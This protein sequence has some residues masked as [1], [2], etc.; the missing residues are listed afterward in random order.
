VAALAQLLGES[1]GMVG[2]RE[3]VA[4]LLKNSAEG[5]RLAPILIQGETGTGKTVLARAMHDASPRG[6]GPFVDLNAGAVAETL[7]EDQL[8][9]HERGAFTDAREARGGFFQEAHRGT[10]FLDEVGLMS[11]ALQGKLLKAIEERTVRRIGARRSEPVDVWVITASNADLAQAMRDGS[12]RADLYYR[13]AGVTLWL[14]PLRE[15]GGD[16]LLL[17]EHFLESA[18]R[19]HEIPPRRLDAGARGVLLAHDWPGNVRELARVM[20]CVAVFADGPVI[21]EG[22]LR[23]QMGDVR[24]ARRAASDRERPPL[25]E[26]RDALERER[27][28][29]ALR[30]TGHNLSRAAERLGMKR[31]TFRYRLERLGLL[32]RLTATS[33]RATGT[34]AAAAETA[35]PTRWEPRRV[36]L[37]RI[38][39]VPFATSEAPALARVLDAAV[40]KVGIFGGRVEARSPTG[41]VAAFGVEIAEDAPRRA[42]HTAMA[43][44]KAAERARAEGDGFTIRL[45]IEVRRLQVGFG[46]GTA[47]LDA[48]ARRE[49]WARLD[50]LVAGAEPDAAVVSDAAAPFLERR[51]E[52]APLDPAEAGEP[53]ARRLVGHASVAVAARRPMTAF[54]GRRSHVEALQGR[55]AAALAG[56][57]KLIGIVG[58][59]GIGKSRLVAE[60]C[61][62]LPGPVL[63]LEGACFSYASAI[64]YVPVLGIMRQICGITEADTAET[65]GASLR[66]R[67]E[68][69]G[70]DGAESAPYLDQLFGLRDGAQRLADLTPDAIRARTLQTL[71]QVIVGVSRRQPVVLIVEDLHWADRPSQDVLAALVDD[72][73]DAAMMVVGTYRPG[74][75]P[76]WIDRPLATQLALSPLSPEESLAVVRSI[77]E[78]DVPDAVTR[79][80]LNKAEGNPF[81]LEEICRAFQ[82]HGG[83]A[84]VSTVPDTIEEVLVARIDGLPGALREILQTAAVLGREFA[85]RLLRAMV[86]DPDTLDGQLAALTGLE[87][88]YQ[89]REGPETVHVFK[90]A[91]TQEVAYGSLS[92]ERRRALHAA[93]GHALERLFDDRLEEVYDRLAYHYSRTEEAAKAVGYLERFARRAARADAHETAVQAWREA[94]QHVER[95]PPDTR[96]R[97]RME[98]LLALPDSLLPLG[99]VGEASALLLQE[100]ERLEQL[101]DPSLAARY[102]FLLARAF[103][104]RNH[105]LVM[106]NA[107]RSIAEAERCGDDATRGAAYGVLAIACALSGAAQRGIECGRRAVALLEKTR[108]LWSLSYSHW[109]LGLCCSEI[110][111]FQEALVAERRAL[112]IAREIGSLPLESSALWVIGII[113]SV[114]G[115][116]ERGIAECREAVAKS[117]DVLYRAINSGFL[118]FAYMEAGDGPAAIAVLE[119]A[120]PPLRQFGLNAHA[121]WFTSFLAEAYRL[122]GRLE[123]AEILAD[124]ARRVATE[125]R[126][127]VAVG[128]AQQSLARIAAARGDVERARSWF[129]EALR[130]FSATQSRYETARTYLDLA[131]MSMRC[132]E[133]E[134]ACRHLG[135][136]DAVFEELDVPR[137][138]ARVAALA[139]E[140]G[141]GPTDAR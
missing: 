47:T 110:G 105:A 38:E 36:A 120:I 33:A 23:S 64:P 45:A 133:R 132:G 8:F 4:R 141:L 112:E 85:A 44:Q 136:A 137:Y 22:L 101:R 138:R 6:Q 26:E 3:N 25:K 55:L 79:L 51:F 123:R 87:F 135:A 109:A 117:G 115:E 5:R 50:A 1:S 53:R 131:V 59:A 83:L 93:A 121:A 68:M 72:L 122:D 39:A 129:A 92:P 96:S 60:F 15:R 114:M 94:L 52:L 7:L 75:R 17:A 27:L 34:A 48:E 74:F 102:Y 98:V 130:T 126:F 56:Q 125:T 46:A 84:T 108:D 80:I 61:R 11:P 10:L 91:L 73:P 139:A 140:W 89:T 124:D 14:P 104:L 32:D 127:D 49:A 100:R 54:V 35:V 69:L 67:L 111:A 62:D 103:M 81:F 41:L 66:R 97:R 65:I 2:V 70:L 76:P 21:T 12:F 113:H 106:E 78:S 71:R 20:E 29:E 30:D 18:C 63:R 42:A 57:G 28:L 86:A 58:E 19:V 43:V 118:G 88:L 37:L 128:W 40:E 99:R 119:E 9:G 95:L 107:G 77:L 13:L 24:P 134:A 90:H 116:W 82:D 16:I 31:N